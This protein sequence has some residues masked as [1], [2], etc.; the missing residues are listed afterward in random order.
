ML[1]DIPIELLPLII[2]KLQFNDTYN[3]LLT[4]KKFNNEF[5][6]DKFK[7]K[8]Q[9]LLVERLLNNDLHKFK[10]EIINLSEKERHEIFL[11]SIH[12]IRTIWLNEQQ[13]FYDMKY[14]LEC[15]MYGSRITNLNEITN[16]TSN[17]FNNHFYNYIVE[18]IGDLTIK[19]REKIQK[20]I[21]DTP[22]LK[23]LHSNFIP[24]KK[25]FY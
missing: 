8:Y 9:Y 11:E 19:D 23:G 24:I 3:L 14:I 17:H 10:K 2:D 4:N 22:V 16:H 7:K 15:M 12:N 18:C 20:N 25:I 1:N 6:K 21:D 13:G 5:G